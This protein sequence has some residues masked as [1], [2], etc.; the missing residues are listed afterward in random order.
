LAPWK[1]VAQDRLHLQ[2]D[3]GGVA[4]PGDVDQAGHEPA[5]LV[6]AKE[7]LALAAF[8]EVQHRGREL[9][10]LVLAGLEE[11][12][13]RIGLEHLQQVLARVAVSGESACRQDLANL[14]V[15]DRDAQHRLGVGGRREQPE[16]AL[17]PRDLTVCVKH[18]D[19]DVVQVLRPVNGR[20]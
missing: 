6:L 20:A 7:Q 17:L 1:A 5:V 8:L 15:D 9:V 13:T 18:L 16:E 14:G 2:S 4:V 11:L 19:A 10:Q 12:V 3:G